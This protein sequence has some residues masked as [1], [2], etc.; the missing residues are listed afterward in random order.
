MRRYTECKM[1]LEFILETRSTGLSWMTSYCVVTPKTPGH[2][3]EARSQSQDLQAI[4]INGWKEEKK[5]FQD[6]SLLR[7]KETR[8]EQ[9]G[10][11][12]EETKVHNKAEMWKRVLG[13]GLVSGDDLY[14]SRLTIQDI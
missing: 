7:Q 12:K 3:I 11:S 5:Q 14:A 9:S 2:A 6:E 13:I 10:D 4:E 1:E 8:W